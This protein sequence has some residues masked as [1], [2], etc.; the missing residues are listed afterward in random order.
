MR[1]FPFFVSKFC[2][3]KEFEEFL[4][5]ISSRYK[6]GDI[7]FSSKKEKPN[8]PNKPKKGEKSMENNS[9]AFNNNFLSLDDFMGTAD[10]YAA[11]GAEEK[12]LSLDDFMGTANAYAAPGAEEKI[13]KGSSILKNKS[14]ENREKMDKAGDGTFT[15]DEARDIFARDLISQTLL[16]IAVGADEF[17]HALDQKLVK[18]LAKRNIK[19][20]D[21]GLFTALRYL[22]DDIDD[23]MRKEEKEEGKA[24]EKTKRKTK[25]EEIKD[26]AVYLSGIMVDA[27]A[28]GKASTTKMISDCIHSALEE[29]GLSPETTEASKAFSVLYDNEAEKGTA[30]LAAR[31][32]EKWKKE[33][34]QKDSE[35]NR[36]DTMSSDDITGL[37]DFCNFV[38]E[39]ME[40][41]AGDNRLE[42]VKDIDK[43]V[44]RV[45]AKHSL[46]PDTTP[47]VIAMMFLYDDAEERENVLEAIRRYT[48]EK[49][50]EEEGEE[51]GEEER[52]EER[53]EEETAGDTSEE[54]ENAEPDEPDEADETPEADETEKPAEDSEKEKAEG[55]IAFS[56][57]V[58]V[59]AQP[60]ETA[61]K[62]IASAREAG[63]RDEEILA[64]ARALKRLG[65]EAEKEMEK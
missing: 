41:A 12:I 34:N 16:A 2:I 56:F 5:K 3:L 8:K 37:K 28:S 44:R 59:K 55:K 32:Y 10:A 48:E 7:Y 52:G 27:L 61:R 29:K 17:I 45:L 39:K 57:K 15:K 11:P 30:L 60:E 42:L 50:R 9:N 1:P 13:K 35:D 40:E 25:E 38:M 20:G 47:A 31:A 21:V 51:E 6:G 65:E 24:E 26:F 36:L 54:A 33:K 58:F 64:L 18:T 22:Y 53:E 46:S 19:L 14:E 49:G 62:L 63:Q 4:R 23:E 43:S